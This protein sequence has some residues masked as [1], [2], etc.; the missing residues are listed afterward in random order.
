MTTVTAMRL[1]S[2]WHADGTGHPHAC[3]PAAPAL[4]LAVWMLWSLL[5][6]QLPAMG[7]RYSV[8]QLFWLAAL[9]ALSGATLQ[10]FVHAFALPAFGGRHRLALSVAS[11]L[12]PALG[13]A[14]ALRHPD[15]AFETMVLLAL[16]CG[17]AC[18]LVASA[19]LQ[20][21]RISVGE[22]ALIVRS[23]HNGWMSWLTTGSFGSF[24]GLAAALPLFAHH[25]FPQAD[26]LT[27]TVWL[28]P[29]LGVLAWPLGGRL[30]DRL[31][32]ARV[33]LWA[34]AALTLGVAALGF[35][36][37][38]RLA[39]F[40]GASA[41][42]FAACGIVNGSTGRMFARVFDAPQQA[43][44]A[45]GFAAAV[46]A[47]GGFVMPKALG[48]SFSLTGTATPALLAFAAFYLSCLAITW[49]HYGR[50]FAPTPC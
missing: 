28:G 13:V 3:Q 38:G 8:N 49:W 25:Q 12:L 5:V 1:N 19:G 2:R 9:P 17:L 16:L 41:W 15:T 7:L 43:R 22:Q 35:A 39:L 6:V 40:L 47:Y 11:L 23:K 42:M 48:T 24:L 14:L 45:R 26:A 46:A 27:A 33:T 21:A 20:G 10:L 32:A 34:F 31:G 44:A 36:L 18:S 37:P 29:L 50:R 30:A 4:A